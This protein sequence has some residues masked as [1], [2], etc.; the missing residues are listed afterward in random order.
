MYDKVMII[1]E[2]YKEISF[3]R[4]ELRLK[5]KMFNFAQRCLM[6]QIVNH[7]QITP[8]KFQILTAVVLNLPINWER[9]LVNLLL[10]EA[11]QIMCVTEVE[12]VVDVHLKSEKRQLRLATKATCIVI[13]V[14]KHRRWSDARDFPYNFIPKDLHQLEMAIGVAPQNSLGAPDHLRPRLVCTGQS[15]LG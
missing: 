9:L 10:E 14:F 11:K 1:Q 12:V 4:T 3:K 8:L 7:D 13:S 5:Y 15:K 2:K 6:G